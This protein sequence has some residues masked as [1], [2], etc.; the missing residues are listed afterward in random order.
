MGAKICSS[1]FLNKDIEEPDYDW[2]SAPGLDLEN[3]YKPPILCQDADDSIDICLSRLVMM[4]TKCKKLKKSQLMTP[5]HLPQRLAP[6]A[7]S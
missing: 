4:M 5:V 6:S 7:T 1:R 2:D 3:V